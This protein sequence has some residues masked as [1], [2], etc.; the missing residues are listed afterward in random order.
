MQLNCIG[1]KCKSNIEFATNS[2]TLEGALTLNKGPF[3]NLKCILRF[4]EHEFNTNL[5]MCII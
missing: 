3:F 4:G 2:Q 1:L 5:G